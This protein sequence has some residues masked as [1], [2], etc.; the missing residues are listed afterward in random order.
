MRGSRRSADVNSRQNGREISAT[1]RLQR[2]RRIAQNGRRENFCRTD[3][4]RFPVWADAG[5]ARDAL[6]L[7]T[8]I[9]TYRVQ[10]SASGAV[11][12]A[13]NGCAAHPSRKLLALGPKT[14]SPF[15]EITTNLCPHDKMVN[16]LKVRTDQT[17]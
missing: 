12:Q 13:V 7:T 15:I 14:C 2:D 5:K 4:A 8:R 3:L 16:R 1:S 9:Y 10:Q 17:E 11:S 6:R